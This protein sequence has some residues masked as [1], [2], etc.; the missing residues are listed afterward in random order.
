MKKDSILVRAS[1][2]D[3]RLMRIHRLEEQLASTPV[4]SRQHRTLGAAI[5]IEADAYRKSLDRGQATATH[6]AKPP[7]VVGL[8]YLKR[9]RRS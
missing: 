4:N 3:A 5:G 9:T 8:G 7:P 6:D 1:E 2:A